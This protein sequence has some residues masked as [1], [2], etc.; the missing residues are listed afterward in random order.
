[1]GES[2]PAEAHADGLGPVSALPL[3]RDRSRGPAHADPLTLVSC[4][5]AVSSEL[6]PVFVA[7]DLRCRCSAFLLAH[8]F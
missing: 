2:V 7:A 8:A 6:S 3:T 1:M 4:V 5:A